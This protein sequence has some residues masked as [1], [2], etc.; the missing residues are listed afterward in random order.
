MLPFLGE[1]NVG[2][3]PSPC[4]APFDLPKPPRPN[5][6]SRHH[7]KIKRLVCKFAMPLLSGQRYSHYLVCCIV[8]RDVL[9][10]IWCFLDHEVTPAA[11]VGK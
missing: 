6:V 3:T 10:S 11:H 9:T 5:L 8:V 4:G 2:T 7:G 1:A